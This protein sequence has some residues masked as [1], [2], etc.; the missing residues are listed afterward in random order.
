[1]KY[2]IFYITKVQGITCLYFFEGLISCK[3]SQIFF[4]KNAL[5]KLVKLLRKMQLF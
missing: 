2:V 3:Y 1:M 5:P 4:S